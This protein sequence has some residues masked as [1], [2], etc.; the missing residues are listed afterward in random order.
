MVGALKRMRD[1]VTKET[2]IQI[3]QGLVQPY[4]SYGPWCPCLGWRRQNIK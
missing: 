1:Y 4:F 3:Y 2:A